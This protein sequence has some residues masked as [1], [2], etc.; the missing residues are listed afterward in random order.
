MARFQCGPCG[1]DGHAVW[2]GVRAGFFVEE[3]TDQEVER[4][5]QALAEAQDEL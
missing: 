2:A 5:E 1:Y 3:M 4:L